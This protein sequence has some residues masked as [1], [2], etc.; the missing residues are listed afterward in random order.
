[1][2]D[3]TNTPADDG[4]AELLD[5]HLTQ[6]N[7]AEAMI[8][9]FAERHPN[10]PD[11]SRCRTAVEKIAKTIVDVECPEEMSLGQILDV[12]RN[13]KEALV[14]TFATVTQADPDLVLEIMRE[15][16]AAKDEKTPT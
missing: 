4:T 16:N 7:Q 13:T 12:E 14:L 2:T 5:E 1:M 10:H 15:Q 9:R 6:L 11:I 3:T 8:D